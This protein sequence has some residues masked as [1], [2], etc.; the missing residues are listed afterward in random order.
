M[1]QFPWMSA[2]IPASP[3]KGEGEGQDGHCLQGY[4]VIM[5]FEFLS[6]QEILL[7]MIHMNLL[8]LQIQSSGLEWLTHFSL[9]R[10]TLSSPP[11]LAQ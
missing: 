8:P 10:L 3:C 7:D 4:K 6:V 5:C 2:E 9:S 11:H 1:E